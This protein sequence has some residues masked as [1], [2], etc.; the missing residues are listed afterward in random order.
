M[1]GSVRKI[2]KIVDGATKVGI[3]ICVVACFAIVSHMVDS[4]AGKVTIADIG[5]RIIMNIRLYLS[6]AFGAGGIIWGYRERK[7]HHDGIAAQQERILALEKRIDPK[8]TSSRLTER[9]TTN[10]ED[11]L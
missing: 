4:L 1:Q 10:P 8:R 9:G 2:D 5:L 3:G 6:W 11:I 7:L